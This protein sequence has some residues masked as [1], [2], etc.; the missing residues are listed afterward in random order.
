MEQEKL[1]KAIEELSEEDLNRIRILK[2][3]GRKVEDTSI[4]DINSMP[5]LYRL[6]LRK[7]LEEM[8]EDEKARKINT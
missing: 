7:A 2:N 1:K 4:D 6:E 8:G 5:L 3:I